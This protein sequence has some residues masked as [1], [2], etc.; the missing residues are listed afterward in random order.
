MEFLRD[1]QRDDWT[2][3]LAKAQQL[4]QKYPDR[5]P[6]ILDR[7]NATTPK[8]TSHRFLVPTHI[9]GDTNQLTTVGHFLRIVRSHVPSLTADQAIYVFVNNSTLPVLSAPLNQLY[10]EHQEKDGFLYLTFST[11]STFGAQAGVVVLG[12][13]PGMAS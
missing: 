13:V 7:A 5:V 1:F 8:P 12:S 3:R 6:I 9:Q 2:N 4:R 10:T 11:E